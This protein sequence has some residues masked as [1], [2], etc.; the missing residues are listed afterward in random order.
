L[1]PWAILNV[2]IAEVEMDTPLS[3]QAKVNS[4]LDQKS[5]EV[6]VKRTAEQLKDLSA[7]NAYSLKKMAGI[8]PPFFSFPNNKT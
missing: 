5:L 8:S 3:F 7:R 1:F 6:S 2:R 4:T